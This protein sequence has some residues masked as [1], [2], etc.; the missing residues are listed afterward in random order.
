MRKSV[1]GV[2]AVLA[3]AFMLL[4]FGSARGIEQG[5]SLVQ[6]I[7]QSNGKPATLNSLFF[8][9][10]VVWIVGG[11]GLMLRSD[12]Y[13]RTFQQIG[14]KVDA[15]LNDV[16]V[17]GNRIWAIGDGGSMVLSTDG[18][19]SFVKNVAISHRGG[20]ST[21]LD[22]YSVQFSDDKHGFIVGD[23]GL[24]LASS[25]SGVSWREQH[26]NTN[27]QLFHLSVHGKKSWVVGAGGVIVH[28]DDGGKNWYPQ[29][30]GTSED[31]NRVVMVNDDRGFV[32]GNN[33]TLLK[34][35]NGGATWIQVPIKER[36]PLF[37][38]SFIDKK[39]GWLVAYKG[40]VLRTYDAGHDWIEQVSPTGA[41]LF[42][43]A[44]FKNRGFAIGRNGVVLAY[45]EKR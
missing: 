9:G 15:G 33:G 26:C 18:G 23:Q 31:L 39:T 4:F 42:A 44:F 13:G 24:I 38:M 16:C 34:T 41:D 11:D 29:R 2:S 20:Q 3:A 1:I 45:Y 10:K 37:G 19:R 35:D 17:L 40:V 5:W 6:T 21:P 32:S 28:T 27:A 25:D 14:V 22:L 30:S 8:D 7:Q 12:D 43:V 36:V